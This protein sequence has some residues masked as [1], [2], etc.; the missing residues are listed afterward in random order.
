MQKDAETRSE[1]GMSLRS[2]R[3]AGRYRVVK[4][5]GGPQL[6]ARLA[7]LGMEEGA[8]IEVERASGGIVL[9]CRTTRIAMSWRTAA[10]LR[11]AP[12]CAEEDGQ[13]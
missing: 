13:C 6:K 8:E 5:G 4:V 9:A 3:K 11:V 7:A 10:F 1:G 2:V 12:D